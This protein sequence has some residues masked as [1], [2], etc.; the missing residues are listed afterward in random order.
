MAETA[1]EK[2]IKGGSFLIESR[3]PAEIFTP[4]DLTDQHRLIAKTA[5]EFDPPPST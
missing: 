2:R 5:S 3:R 4:E 1:V